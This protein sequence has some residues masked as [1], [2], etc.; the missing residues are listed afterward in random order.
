MIVQMTG[1][2]WGGGRAGGVRRQLQRTHREGGPVTASRT[3]AQ[4]GTE[5]GQRATGDMLWLLFAWPRA[6]V[7][8]HRSGGSRGLFAAEETAGG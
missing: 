4:G 2:L 5:G 3:V 1:E 7:R 6:I 8:R